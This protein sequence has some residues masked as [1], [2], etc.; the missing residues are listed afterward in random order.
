MSVTTQDFVSGTSSPKSAKFSGHR[1]CESRD[2]NF[3]YYHVTSR[4]S[5]DQRFMWL[6]VRE[7][8]TV[9]QHLA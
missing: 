5:R 9:S 2:I 3:L 1:S 7:P 6:E 4:W 8:L